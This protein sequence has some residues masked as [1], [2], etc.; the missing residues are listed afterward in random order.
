[1]LIN[2][3]ARQVPSSEAIGYHTADTVLRGLFVFIVFAPVWFGLVWFGLVWF[4]L[5]W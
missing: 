2:H 3:I 1:M 5:V 4:G